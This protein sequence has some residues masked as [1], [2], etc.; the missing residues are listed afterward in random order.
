MLRVVLSVLLPLVLPTAL[1]FAYA[2]YV[3]QQAEAEGEEEPKEL[4]VPWSWLIS[5]GLVLALIALAVTVMDPD[6]KP[7]AVYEPPHLEN[8][9]LVPGR[10]RP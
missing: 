8:G 1:Y 2:W 10:M 3:G 7:G 5:T 9:K 6:A 4:D